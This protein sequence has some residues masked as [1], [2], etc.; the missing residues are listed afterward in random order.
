M[1]IGHQRGGQ[2]QV[3]KTRAVLYTKRRKA[4]KDLS[5]LSFSELQELFL[6]LSEKKELN[7]K[8]KDL[9]ARVRAE[10]Q[11]IADTH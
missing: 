1:N 8:K 10:L 5:K 9:L 7:Q 4:M 11:R 6:E 2:S 3:K